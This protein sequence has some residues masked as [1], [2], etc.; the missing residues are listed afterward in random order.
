L[1]SL[2]ELILDLNEIGDVGAAKLAEET[3]HLKSLE[4]LNLRY[5]KISDEEIAKL[6]KVIR[7]TGLKRLW[8]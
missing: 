8:V 7:V 2:K 5:N 3:K 1:T 4:T 6:R